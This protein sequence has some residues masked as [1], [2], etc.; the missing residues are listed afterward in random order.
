MIGRPAGGEQQE[1]LLSRDSADVLPESWRIG[2]KVGP[3]L[4]AENAMHEIASM[5]VHHAATIPGEFWRGGDGQHSAKFVSDVPT[6]SG[7]YKHLPSL[8]RLG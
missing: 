5:C 2:N 6:G 3:A 7:F 8:E 4:R 1:L